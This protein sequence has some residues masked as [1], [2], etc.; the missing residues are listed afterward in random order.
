LSNRS[1]TPDFV[2]RHAMPSICGRVTGRLK[3]IDLVDIEPIGLAFPT[4]EEWLLIRSK[5]TREQ[6]TGVEPPYTVP[7]NRTNCRIS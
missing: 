5:S 7:Q 2:R 3:R 4:D 6:H 1:A